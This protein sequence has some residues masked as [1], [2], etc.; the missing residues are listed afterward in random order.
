MD[1]NYIKTK[2]RAYKVALNFKKSEFNEQTIYAKLEKQGFPIAIAKEV[3]SNIAI[4]KNSRKEDFDYKKFSLNTFL[5][6]LVLSSLI[7]L[8][9][10]DFRQSTYVLFSIIGVTFFVHTLTTRY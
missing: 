2:E 8:F 10:G 3:A 6:A 1:N 7:F 4:E 9:T 5:V